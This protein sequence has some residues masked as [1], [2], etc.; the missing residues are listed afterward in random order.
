MKFATFIAFVA[1]VL[2]IVSHVSDATS[3]THKRPV[4]EYDWMTQTHKNAAQSNKEGSSNDR[5]IGAKVVLSQQGVQYIV[6][7]LLPYITDVVLATWFPDIDGSSKI[8]LLGNVTYH[9]D[10][11]HLTSL[12]LGDSGVVPVVLDTPNRIGTAVRSGQVEF[13]CN[14]TYREVRWPHK[15]D[16]GHLTGVALIDSFNM[17]TT[18]GATPAGR[19]TVEGTAAALALGAV[20]ARV[21][22]SSSDAFYQRIIDAELPK[23]CKQIE[24]GVSDQLPGVIDDL[25]TAALGS[26]PIQENITYDI[27][28]DYTFSRPVSVVTI[29]KAAA[30]TTTTTNNNNN[31]NIN[32]G[33]SNKNVKAIVAP[34]R[35]EVFANIEGSGHTPGVPAAPLPEGETGQMLEFYLSNWSIASISRALWRTGSFT[36]VLTRANAPAALANMFSA[37]HYAAIAPGLQAAYG[38]DAEVAIVSSAAA[39]P[40]VEPLTGGYTA[41]APAEVAFL[42]MDSS[43]ATFTVAFVASSNASYK[44]SLAV[45]NA[46]IVGDVTLVGHSAA[47]VE[48]AVGAVD[49][50]ALAGEIR[51]ALE[52]GAKH[53]SEVL[54][55]GVIPLPSFIGVEFKDAEI[56]WGQGYALFSSDGSYI[57][58]GNFIRACNAKRRALLSK[59]S[60]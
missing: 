37:G 18:I 19:P 47:V 59:H 24:S 1:L 4:T 50:K 8:S 17:T 16:S 38:A 30:A 25:G 31:N 22:G 10:H 34:L 48:T 58:P 45:K 3:A 28:F 49:A 33:L 9:I 60:S 36:K 5:P 40:E 57:P 14:W 11:L 12:T 20:K 51:S 44:G 39:P 41:T 13:A 29:N 15:S 56:R 35:F 6:D 43:K 23:I 32:K 46:R 21:S 52:L 54:A 26:A 53:A 2:S 55:S 7:T 42:V 27:G